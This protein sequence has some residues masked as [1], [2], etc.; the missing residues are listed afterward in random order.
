MALIAPGH[1]A[2]APVLRHDFPDRPLPDAIGHDGQ[3]FYAIAR[4]PMHLASAT[5]SVDRPRYRA[6]RILFPVLAWVLHPTGGGP[7]LVLALVLVNVAGLL[8]GG[9]AAGALSQTRGGPAWPALVFPLLPGASDCLRLGVPDTLALALVLV[10]LLLDQRGFPRLAVLA[11]I[12][13]VLTK[14]SS[15]LVLAGYGIW[16]G[17]PR[18]FRLVAVPALAG[19]A[20]WC[21]LRLTLHER[22]LHL[23]EFAPVTGLVHALRFWYRH[24]PNIALLF[25]ATV[26]IA[27]LALRQRGLRDPL[28]GCIAIQLAF[29]PT[30]SFQ[31]LA[32]GHDASRALLPLFVLG[33][34]AL[35]APGA[36]RAKGEAVMPKVG[37]PPVV[38]Y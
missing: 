16:R 37:S 19:A 21:W 36:G 31:V 33:G 38:R 17:R 25:L 14:E 28:G 15:F 10:A 30:L 13:A 9:V 32:I 11:G 26:G 3:F 4:Q 6:Q 23:E 18:G 35:C 1:T 12:A 7:G 2:A 24:H 27:V 22:S 29:I 5:K 8:V 34:L 20:W